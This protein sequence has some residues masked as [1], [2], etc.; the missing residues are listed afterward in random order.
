MGE[1]KAVM[2]YGET[3]NGKLSPIT[4]ELLGC[5]R[6]LADELAEELICLLV[7]DE[8]GDTP[9]LAVN[10]G[11][12]KVYQVSNQA[13]REY[14]SDSYVAVLENIFYKLSPQIILFGQTEVGRDLAPRLA[15][16][17][18]TG[19]T[20]DCVELYIN[21]VTK[22]LEQEKPVYGGNARAVFVSDSSPQIV[23]VRKKSM[24]PLLP[25]DSRKGQIISLDADL[26]LP[27][28]KG[29]VKIIEKVIEEK[30]GLKLEDAPVI[31][32][33]GRGIGN[34]AA[35]EKLHEAARLLAGAVGAS[36]HPC[37]HEWISDRVQIGL[38]GKIVAPDI[39]IAVGISG[40]SQHMAGCLGSKVIIAINKNPEANIFNFARYGIVADWKEALP[41]FSERIKEIMASQR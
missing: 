3:I 10:Y 16:R 4:T 30:S 34:A 23:T 17:L 5:G 35:F 12:D 32:A 13:L 18:Q 21:P 1:N 40:A 19:L 8:L 31:I 11:A 25:D 6:R 37:D 39:Y 41:A 15:F 24:S 38:T 26:V 22:K 28:P 36:K 29:G 7:G 27:N 9:D 14:S 2:I 33:G 20:M